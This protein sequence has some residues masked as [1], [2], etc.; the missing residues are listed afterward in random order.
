MT[1]RI[2]E[3]VRELSFETFVPTL[4]TTYEGKVNGKS[5]VRTANKLLT[6]NY[7]FVRGEQRAIEEE[8]NG[9]DE[10]DTQS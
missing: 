3:K 10:D 4:K 8:Q 1:E 5:V 9:T 2:K 7:V 6:F